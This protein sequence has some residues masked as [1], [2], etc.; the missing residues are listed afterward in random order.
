MSKGVYGIESTNV[1]V[2]N[3]ARR[4]CLKKNDTGC[5]D[6]ACEEGAQAGSI[7][8]KIVFFSGQ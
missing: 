5:K 3:K 1:I 6:K 7:N 2:G 8:Q 4:V